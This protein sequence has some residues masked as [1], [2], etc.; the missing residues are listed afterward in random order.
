MKTKL[1]KEVKISIGYYEK[2]TNVTAKQLDLI[3]K[4]MEQVKPDSYGQIILKHGLRSP[5][6]RISGKNA[7]K[8]IGALQAGHRII[9]CDKG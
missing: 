4:L 1:P 2:S 9:F 5:F 8:L 7:S 3:D 6:R